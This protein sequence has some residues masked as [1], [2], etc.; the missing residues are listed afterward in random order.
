MNFTHKKMVIERIQT[1]KAYRF[2]LYESQKQVKLSY[3]VRSQIEGTL[4]WG[5]VAPWGYKE[6][7]QGSGNAHFLVLGAS[8]IELFSL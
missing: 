2:S 4:G 8:Y 1:C 6:E 3:G 5:S 7:F